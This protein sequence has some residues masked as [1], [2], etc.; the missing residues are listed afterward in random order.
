MSIYS[1]PKRHNDFVFIVWK[2]LN[3]ADILIADPFI[4]TYAHNLPNLKWLQLTWA[5]VDM[6]AARFQDCPAPPYLITRLGGCF[7]QAM[8]DYVL[9][10]IIANERRF[11]E[12]W[13]AQ[14]E[15]IW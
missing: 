10:Y 15:H 13:K 9:G 3:N 14:T 8:S 6:I 12:S 7:G 4:S 2:K 5:G 1:T 11:K